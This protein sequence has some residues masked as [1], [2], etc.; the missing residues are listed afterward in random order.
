MR[1]QNTNR[2]IKLFKM[3]LVNHGLLFGLE[4]TLGGG[5]S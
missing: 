5:F 3:D 2:A 1:E 4:L